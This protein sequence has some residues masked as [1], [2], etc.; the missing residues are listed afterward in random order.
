MRSVSPVGG[1]YWFV[2]RF[3]CVS[4]ICSQHSLVYDYLNQQRAAIYHAIQISFIE[5]IPMTV[6]REFLLNVSV[7]SSLHN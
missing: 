2:V 4:R 7:Y 6:R 3:M 1:K 5:N